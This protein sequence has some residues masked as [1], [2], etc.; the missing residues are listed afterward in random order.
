M[1]AGDF[2]SVSDFFVVGLGFDL[3]GAYLLARG[4]RFKP[5]R[6][7]LKAGSFFDGNPNVVV[8]GIEDRVDGSFGLVY[9]VLGFGLQAVGYA[10]DLSLAPQEDGD[11]LRTVMA[12][13][14]T[15][16][17]VGLALGY[18]W[19]RREHHIKRWLVEMAHWHASHA[20][21]EPKRA[22][23]PM[24]GVLASYGEIWF[25]QDSRDDGELHDAYVKRMFGISRVLTADDRGWDGN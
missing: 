3:V 6:L 19:L 9:L 21:K 16:V 5:S 25:G 4:L 12:I 10:I 15:T 18:W 2:L 11:E 13:L 1:D 20:T 17:V 7:A 8:G 22:P 23:A 14:L 24:P